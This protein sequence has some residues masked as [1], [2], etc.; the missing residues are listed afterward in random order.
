MLTS[1]LYDQG[2]AKYDL[3]R[4]VHAGELERIRRGAYAV[5][6]PANTF[7]ADRHRRQIAAA[8]ARL[9]PAAVLREE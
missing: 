7:A 8:L 9:D 6:L 1:Q 2:L 3:A 5:P 4:L